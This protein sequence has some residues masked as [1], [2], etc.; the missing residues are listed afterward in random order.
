MPN[1]EQKAQKKGEG[2]R[3]IISR[4]GKEGGEGGLQRD[5]YVRQDISN[6]I[7]AVLSSHEGLMSQL[8]VIT[9]ELEA[10]NNGF[11]NALEALKNGFNL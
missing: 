1:Q 10:Y 5:V 7:D 8:P 2:M 11:R 4:G 6:M 3:S 9:T